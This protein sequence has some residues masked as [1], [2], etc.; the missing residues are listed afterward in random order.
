MRKLWEFFKKLLGYK[1]IKYFERQFPNIKFDEKWYNHYL[2]AVYVRACKTEKIKLKNL[3]CRIKKEDGK[4]VNVPLYQSPMYKYLGS[5]DKETYIKYHT[6][7]D[8]T[9]K[10][11]VHNCENY[12]QLIK[13]LDENGYDETRPICVKQNNEII[14]GQHRASYLL[15]K[16]G[17][18]YEIT[19]FKLY[20]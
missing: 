12:E 11:Y 8:K 15:K 14:D 20:Y 5:E 13:T 1:N 17:E 3:I 19:V 10:E 2:S 6:L 7:V 16:F 9:S 4:W 18:D